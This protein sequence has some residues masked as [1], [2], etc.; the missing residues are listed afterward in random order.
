MNDIVM[1]R[2]SGRAILV[3]VEV[4]VAIDVLHGCIVLQSGRDV[5]DRLQFDGLLYEYH[6]R[7]CGLV[8]DDM[9]MLMRC[10]SL[11]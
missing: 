11:R 2:L 8:G 5:L 6:R 4:V 10:V 3:V 1:R 9:G 7:W